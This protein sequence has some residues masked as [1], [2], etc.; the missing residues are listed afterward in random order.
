YLLP[1]STLTNLGMTVNARNLEWAIV[2]LL[3]HPLEEMQAIGRRLKEVGLEITPTLLKY[4]EE[5]QHLMQTIP[6]LKNIIWE[7]Q[8]SHPTTPKSDKEPVRIVSYDYDA[9]NKLVAALIYRFGADSYDNIM[10]RVRLMTTADKKA[11]ID[12]SLKYRGPH[13]RPLRELEHVYYTFDILMDYGAFRD[14]QRHRIA[15]QTNQLLTTIH[16]YST[17][18]EIEEVGLT[19]E[20]DAAMEKAA[21]AFKEISTKFPDEAQYIVPLGYKKRTLFTWNLRELHH[22]IPLRSGKKGHQSYRRIAQM[23]YD[24]LME[25]HPLLASYISVDKSD[26]HGSTISK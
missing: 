21:G 20:Y 4:A 7:K 11:I 9:E 24:K 6:A 15:T 13:D 1:A 2:K 10:K 12:E 17:P 25:I 22:F 5:N 8:G 14:I 26:E 23:C 18:S 19:A 16:G 3:S